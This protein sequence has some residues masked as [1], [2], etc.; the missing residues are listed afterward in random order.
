MKMPA[1]LLCPTIPP[2]TA[3]IKIVT[4]SMVQMLTKMVL[5]TI[6]LVGKIAMTTTLNPQQPSKIQTVM[7]TQH[8]LTV[9]TATRIRP[10]Y[11]K[12]PTVMDSLTNLAQPSLSMVSMT[13]WSPVIRYSWMTSPSKYGFT[14][15]Q[16]SS[17]DKSSWS[18]TLV[19]HTACSLFKFQMIASSE[20]RSEAPIK[21]SAK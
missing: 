15:L 5:S 6:S 9:M 20:P 12:T 18:R 4:E 3:S 19:H 17:T 21:I 1:S 8:G 11:Q 10:S 14:P 7:D 16:V 13:F 2:L